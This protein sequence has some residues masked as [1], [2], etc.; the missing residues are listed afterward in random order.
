MAEKERIAAEAKAAEEKKI[1][2]ARLEAERIAEEEA[3]EEEEEEDEEENREPTPEE[4]DDKDLIPVK[5]EFD[6]NVWQ[7]SEEPTSTVPG[8]LQDLIEQQAE[9]Q[10][11][12][13]KVMTERE[14]DVEW[15]RQR[16][17][18]RPPLVI[19]HLKDRA[20]P[21]GTTVKLTCNVSGPGVTVRWLK[22][23][24]PI[25]I[26]PSK[27]KFFSSEGLLSLEILELNRKDEGEYT[28]L[29][30]NKNG[31]T[32]TVA[33]VKVYEALED[34]PELKPTIISIK[35]NFIKVILNV[36][37]KQVAKVH[38]KKCIMCMI[39]YVICSSCRSLNNFVFNC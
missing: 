26:N 29:V 20:A 34:K 35:G 14:R 21:K 24:N 16:Q 6:A 28:C 9:E 22:N 18:M 2:A 17:M 12:P 19:S 37:K 30:K 3:E 7:T 1:E 32:E 36:W 8:I 39:K 38:Q 4:D 27:Y 11:E 10:T 33:K 25:E 5:E 23:G 13:E 15:Q 31:E